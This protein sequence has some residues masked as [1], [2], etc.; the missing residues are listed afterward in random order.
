MVTLQCPNYGPEVL[1]QILPVNIFINN[2]IVLDVVHL[3]MICNCFSVTMKELNNLVL[4]IKSQ[5]VYVVSYLALQEENLTLEEYIVFC[6][7]LLH[8]MEKY[9]NYFWCFLHLFTK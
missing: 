4:I 9:L 6:L 2:W 3:Y 5:K 7:F 1:G 8:A